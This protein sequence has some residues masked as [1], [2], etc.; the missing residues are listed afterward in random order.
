MSEK[1]VTFDTPGS[2]FMGPSHQNDPSPFPQTPG[3]AVFGLNPP[4]TAARAP[5]PVVVQPPPPPPYVPPSTQS[6]VC[7]SPLCC[8]LGCCRCVIL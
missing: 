2:H 7:C 1:T 5:P 3:G 8:A 6:N 4:G